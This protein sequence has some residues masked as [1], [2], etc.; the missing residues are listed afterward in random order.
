MEGM[1]TVGHGVEHVLS[2]EFF[3]GTITYSVPRR[4][5]SGTSCACPVV[6][7]EGVSG[8]CR[9]LTQTT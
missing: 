5:F 9:F 2:H 3:R 8:F 1:F 4:S 6:V 7:V